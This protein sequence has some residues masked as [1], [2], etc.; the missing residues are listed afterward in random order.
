MASPAYLCRHLSGPPCRWLSRD[1]GPVVLPRAPAGISDLVWGTEM[2]LK[3][4]EKEQEAEERPSRSLLL[5][6]LLCQVKKEVD[7]PGDQVWK[8]SGDRRKAPTVLLRRKLIPALSEKTES[9]HCHW[10]CVHGGLGDHTLRG[11]GSGMVEGWRWATGNLLSSLCLEQSLSQ[12]SPHQETG[13][14]EVLFK[15][16]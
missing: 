14:R 3:K 4:K 2:L 1:P 7:V 5:H 11:E 10:R 6:P 9:S 15:P 13:Q 16:K 12:E 8:E